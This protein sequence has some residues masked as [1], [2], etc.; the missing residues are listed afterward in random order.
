MTKMKAFGSQN[1]TSTKRKK[2]PEI[3]RKHQYI[4]NLMGTNKTVIQLL[5]HS[6]MAKPNC[7]MLKDVDSCVSK[8]VQVSS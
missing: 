7:K 2:N 6:A 1:D 5:L 4:T 8:V 3:G